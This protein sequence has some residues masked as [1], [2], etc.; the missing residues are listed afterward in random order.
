M[1]TPADAYRAA[2]RRHFAQQL[3]QYRLRYRSRSAMARA[4]AV[5]TS[6]VAHWLRGAAIPTADTLAWIALQLRVT[7]TSLLDAR[8]VPDD[9]KAT[10]A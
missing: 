6:T 9:R 10:A 8:V 7:P 5:P 1:T 4:F 2:V 3:Q